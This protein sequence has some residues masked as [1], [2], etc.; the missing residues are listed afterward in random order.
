MNKGWL[1]LA[2]LG[3]LGGCSDSGTAIGGVAGFGG[4]AGAAGA[5]AGATSGG[6]GGASAG[7]G[8]VAAGGAAQGGSGAGGGAAGVGAAAGAGGVGGEV[9]WMCDE[10]A[11]PL[12]NEGLMEPAGLDGC[13]DGMARIDTQVCM[14]RWEAFLV[15]V[16][17]GVEQS[18]S[19]YFNPGSATVA[20][21]SAPSAVP[22]GYI[23]GA[24]AEQA[25]VE[26]G[27]RLCTRDEWELGC[28]GSEARVYPYGFM[29]VAGACNDYRA[30]H[31]VVELFG[32]TDSW[33]WNELDNPCISQQ[34]DTLALTGSFDQC[35]TPE[36]IFDLVG[37]LHEWIADP[38]GT[39]KG[40]FYVDATTNGAGC[41]Y[42]TTAHAF[43]YGD[44][45][46]GFRCCSDD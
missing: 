1:A 32:T 11:M 34:P 22:Q 31:P 19:P 41:G 23:S 21:R 7:A 44:Y 29:R 15:E 16:S 2:A 42:T 8:G 4:G 9:P 26:S 6:A 24:Q 40:G 10:A 46:T 36:G 13:P 45:S 17:G 25:C 27:K 14:D 18:W 20:A 30:V 35:Q 38:A 43:S 33:I 12:P 5:S 39:F 28:R 3:V 37:N